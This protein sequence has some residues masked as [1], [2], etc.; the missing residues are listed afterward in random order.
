MDGLQANPCKGDNTL[1]AGLQIHNTGPAFGSLAIL[2]L[3]TRI[4]K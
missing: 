1:V 3:T 2:R 4:L